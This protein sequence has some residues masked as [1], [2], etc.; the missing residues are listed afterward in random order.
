MPGLRLAAAAAAVFITAGW[1]CG[2]TEVTTEELVAVVER[3]AI[4]FSG[5]AIPDQVL[6][7]F[8]AQKLVII[9]ETHFLS[10]HR[11]FLA[12]LVRDLHARGYRQLLMELP[13]MV[14]WLL[15]DY[16]RNGTLLPGWT[17]PEPLVGGLIEPVRAFNRTLPPDQQFDVRAIDV[18][19]DDYGGASAFR[20][21]LTVL[22]GHLNPAG[23]VQEFLDR[24][25]SMPTA[26]HASLAT[27]S[28]ALADGKAELTAQWGASRYATVVEL[29]EVEDASVTVRERRQSD[30]DRSVRDREHEI[31]RIA[32]LRLRDYPFRT[33]LN[34]GGNHAQ[35]SYLKGTEQQWLG[36]YLVHESTAVGGP[37][38]VLTVT[39]ARI[40]SMSGG[41]TPLWDVRNRSPGNELWRTMH[42]RWPTQSVWLPLDDPMFTAGGIPVNYED[43]IYVCAPKRHYD[44]ALLYPMAH[45]MPDR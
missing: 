10:E 7:Q 3:D 25:Y 33:L 45:R 16:A 36:D 27:L 30:Y 37:T 19:L 12:A 24:P 44:V 35:K 29:A 26:Q 6:D 38:L 8:A 34:V 40:M 21:L 4:P 42:E 31:K 5:D 2:I 41:T 13:Q 32:D 43:E 9:G 20:D 11:A 17:P 15:S 1:A 39:A 28:A 18:N 14:D 22:A 23:P